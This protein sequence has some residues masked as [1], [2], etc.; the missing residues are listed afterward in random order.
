MTL[1]TGTTPEP[2]DTATRARSRGVEVPLPALFRR[3]VRP[4]A[5][6]V[7]Q[8]AADRASPGAA[9]PDQPH[10]HRDLPPRRFTSLGSFSSRFAELVGCSP[11]AYQARYA[12]DARLL[13]APARVERSQRAPVPLTWLRR[14]AWGQ[15]S[16]SQSR[17]SPPRVNPPTVVGSARSGRICGRSPTL[18]RDRVGH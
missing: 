16:S 12:A 6:P 7:R 10:C 1:P 2:L 9:A 3:G 8:R 13:R 18:S 17:R 5:S 11:T 15:S 4:N 14:G